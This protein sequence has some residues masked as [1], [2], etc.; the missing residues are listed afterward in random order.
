MLWQRFERLQG[1][2][3]HHEATVIQTTAN[4]LH[5][6]PRQ[7]R[8][9]QT[10]HLKPLGIQTWKPMKCLRFDWKDRVGEAAVQRGKSESCGG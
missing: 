8:L 1:R 5:L 3:G 6:V 10:V 9:D 7:D 2:V 4:L